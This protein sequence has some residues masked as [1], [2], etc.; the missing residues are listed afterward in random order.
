MESRLQ[1]HP[2]ILIEK[3]NKKMSLVYLS[4][5][6]VEQEVIEC[7]N[8]LIEIGHS[9]IVVE[10]FD[11]NILCRCD[12]VITNKFDEMDGEFGYATSQGIICY[13]YKNLMEHGLD[14]E[15]HEIVKPSITQM[16]T[17]ISMREYRNNIMKMNF[18]EFISDGKVL[19]VSY[20]NIEK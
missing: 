14:L 2:T 10:K 3:E 20:E 15:R 17:E 8:K 12:V 7:K 9:V 11:W 16:T 6:P 13:S 19:S 18:G 4:G 5:N 1:Y